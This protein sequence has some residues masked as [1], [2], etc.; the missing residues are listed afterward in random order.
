[1]YLLQGSVTNTWR[2]YKSFSEVF[3]HLSIPTSPHIEIFLGVDVR[4]GN[5]TKT[6]YLYHRIRG[7]SVRIMYIIH[8][9]SGALPHWSLIPLRVWISSCVSPYHV[10]MT[11]CWFEKK[12]L[13]CI[14]TMCSGPKLED[15]WSCI[16]KP[17]KLSLYNTS[18][19]THLRVTPDPNPS[20]YYGTLCIIKLLSLCNIIHVVPWAVTS[21]LLAM[22]TLF[23]TNMTGL[24]RNIS[25]SRR[26][27][28]IVSA[29]SKLF[30]STTE[31]ITRYASAGLLPATRSSFVYTSRTYDYTNY[32]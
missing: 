25:C 11:A 10:T 13:Y 4:E 30:L 15:L 17:K 22:S 32:Y 31:K 20:A 2:G 23:P 16:G 27:F 18:I 8:N 3:E 5:P 7:L 28:R 29:V 24:D 19:P 12:Y 1:L 26:F 6:F 14:P 21:L 9:E